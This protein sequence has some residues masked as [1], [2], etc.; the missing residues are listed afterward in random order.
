MFI[1]SLFKNNANFD[2]YEHKHVIIGNLTRK[3]IFTQQNLIHHRTECPS[4]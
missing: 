3:L 2:I 4:N 1:E